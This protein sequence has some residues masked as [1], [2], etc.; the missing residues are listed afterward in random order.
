MLKYR[1]QFNSY[2][3]NEIKIMHNPDYKRRLSSN[4]IKIQIH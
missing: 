3:E 4:I 1:K 2:E